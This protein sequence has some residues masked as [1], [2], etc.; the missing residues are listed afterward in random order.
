MWT[1]GSHG[2]RLHPILDS[3][4]HKPAIILPYDQVDALRVKETDP[5]SSV[6]PA[7]RRVDDEQAAALKDGDTNSAGLVKL[8][9]PA[10]RRI[11]IRRI[12]GITPDVS[13]AR[14]PDLS[15]EPHPK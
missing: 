1:S 14:E 9:C 11:K 5:P 3:S 12:R 7:Y 8:L 4:I 2:S 13:N 15:R 10:V 6:R